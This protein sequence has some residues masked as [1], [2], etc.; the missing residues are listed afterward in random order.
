MLAGE[1][2]AQTADTHSIWSLRTENDTISTFPKGSDQN[3]TA[4][5]QVSWTSG[6]DAVPPSAAALAHLLWG[7]GTVRVGLGLSQQIYT[8]VDTTRA[9]PNPR[10]RPYAGALLGIASLLHDTATTR[11]IATLSLGVIGPWALGEEVQNGAHRLIADTLSKGWSHQLPNEPAIEL[12]DQRTWRVPLTSIGAF[13]TDALPAIAAGIGT[14]RDYV[15]ATMMLRVG[16][17]LDADFGPSRIRPGISGGDAFADRDHLAWY[18]FVAVDGQA[19]A[20]DA[21]LDGDLWRK[22]A[23]VQSEPL[24]G[25]FEMGL[26]MIWRGVRLTYVQTWQTQQFRHQT[27]GLFNFGSLALSMR[28]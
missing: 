18:A 11:D 5:N 28:F 1:A 6:T 26:A 21:F 2:H 24:L 12:L 3:Y 7:D 14:V 25:E 4:G 13:E 9:I 27:A 15:E 17:G 8:P 16:Q 23:H 22:S 10:D 20:R 19:I